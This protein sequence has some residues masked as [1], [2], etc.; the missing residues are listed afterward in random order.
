LCYKD[1]ANLKGYGPVLD[2]NIDPTIRSDLH[3]SFKIG[4]EELVPDEQDERRANGGAMA[5]EN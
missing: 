5:R 3:Q 1:V 2:S 4:W